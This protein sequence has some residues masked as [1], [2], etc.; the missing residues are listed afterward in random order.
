MLLK[1]LRLSR[2]QARPRYE[3]LIRI[4]YPC[5]PDH[6]AAVHSMCELNLQHESAFGPEAH[7]AHF[8]Y[9]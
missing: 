3:P 5:N 7:R 1:P 8:P 9:L 6:R 4:Y 2:F